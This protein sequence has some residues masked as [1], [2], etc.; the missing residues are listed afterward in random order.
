MRKEIIINNEKQTKPS[1]LNP[2]ELKNTVGDELA[3]IFVAHGLKNYNELLGITDL[4]KKEKLSKA[5]LKKVSQLIPNNDG[6]I[7][8]LTSFQKEYLEDKLRYKKNFQESKK[9]FS[10]LKP[11]LQF[12]RGEFTDGYDLLDDILDYFG[13]ENTKEIFETSEKQAALFKKQNNARVDPINLYIWLRRGEIDF[14]Y[15]DLPNYDQKALTQWID[16]KGWEKHVEDPTYFKSLPSIFKKFGVALLLVPYLKN[17][18]YG[19]VRWIDGH[20]LI[21][22]SDRNRDLAT[23]WFTLFHELG[24]VILHQDVEIYEGDINTSLTFNKIEREANKFANR[25]L[26]N[27]DELRKSVFNRKNIDTTL[28]ARGLAEEF[29][30]KTM[31]ASYWLIKAQYAPTLQPRIAIDFIEN[32]Q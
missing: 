32:Y 1:V 23:C 4:R 6:I 15:L 27:G 17:T 16:K 2:L 14:K 21:E 19:A 5:I 20:P 12:M 3:D 9:D 8:F 7:D 29:G 28:T 31:F 22:I 18:V 30:V 26:F 11:A 25:Y 13:A 10:R 24:H